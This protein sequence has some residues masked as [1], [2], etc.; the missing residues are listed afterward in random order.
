MIEFTNKRILV[1]GAGASGIAVSRLLPSLGARVCLVDENEPAL[2]VANRYELDSLG[3][4]CRFAVG[5]ICDLECDL[6]VVS[7][8][9]SLKS[10]LMDELRNRQIPVYSEIEVAFQCFGGRIVSIT[11]TNGKTTTTRMVEAVMSALEVDSISAGNIGYPFSALVREQP[12]NEWVSLELSSFQLENIS[13]FRSEIAVLL[14]LAPDHLDR[15]ETLESYYLAKARIFENQGPNDVA[16]IQ[17]EAKEIL[18][19]LG[20]RFSGRV[21]TFSHQDT[22]SDLY[23][24]QGFVVSRIPGWSGLVYDMSA[25]SLRGTHNVENVMAALLCGHAMGISLS[26]IQVAL[27]AFRT[28]THRFEILSNTEGLTVVND[29]KSTNPAS[30]YAA[31]KASQELLSEDGRLWLVAGGESKQLSF[32]ILSSLVEERVKGLFLF[33]RSRH[34]LGTLFGPFTNCVARESLKESVQAVFGVARAGDLILFSPGCASY[35]QFR[36][37]AERGDYFKAL[38]REQRFDFAREGSSERPAVSNRFDRS[39]LE[40]G[41]SLIERQ[42]VLET[43]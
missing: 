27:T 10:P 13:E 21:L 3:V 43:I 2:D 20:C 19:A 32:D 7:P 8:G 33:G 15:H 41:N 6:A 40:R 22:S 17:R 4:D 11:G 14:N 12:Q 35:D 29:S 38:I 5:S 36:N 28:E 1:V 18:D 9:V 23:Y 25:G 39:V 30:L 42:S 26:D 34:E 37:Y 24:A 16:I 31:I